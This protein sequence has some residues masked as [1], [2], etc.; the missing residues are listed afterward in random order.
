MR[1]LGAGRRQLPSDAED[2][3]DIA[4]PRP[5]PRGVLTLKRRGLLAAM[6]TD[7]SAAEVGLEFA[8]KA[9]KCVVSVLSNDVVINTALLKAG[10]AYEIF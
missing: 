10:V 1:R 5:K 3:K 2:L 7:L 6:D 9:S 4:E 8:A